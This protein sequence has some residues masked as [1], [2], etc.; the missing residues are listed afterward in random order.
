MPT[1]MTE[2]SRLFDPLYVLTMSSGKCGCRRFAAFPSVDMLPVSDRQCLLIMSL[3]LFYY[4]GRDFKE[5]AGLPGRFVQVVKMR[6]SG[7]A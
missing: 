5:H 4:G 1:K 7:A 2:R 6:V 3:A